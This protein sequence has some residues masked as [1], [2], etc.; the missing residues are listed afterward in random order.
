[1]AG[2]TMLDQ[3]ISH[4]LPFD[5]VPHLHCTCLPSCSAPVVLKN[6]QQDGQPSAASKGALQTPGPNQRIS[7]VTPLK[8]VL[9]VHAGQQGIRPAARG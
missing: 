9:L 4:E 7:L 5:Q 3:Y 6:A 1:M 8:E 2:E